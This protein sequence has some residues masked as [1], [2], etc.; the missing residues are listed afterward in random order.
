MRAR[1]THIPKHTFGLYTLPFLPR[2]IIC[3]STCASAGWQEWGNPGLS[4]SICVHVGVKE[5]KL[6]VCVP[7]CQHVG[8]HSCSRA[9][10]NSVCVWYIVERAQ[11]RKC[12]LSSMCDMTHLHVWHGSFMCVAWLIHMCGPTHSHVWHDPF[13]CVA[14]LI[15]MCGMTHEY[16]WYD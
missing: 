3:G 5:E 16:F 10:H 4:S 15:H 11:T 7:A 1:R 13:T 9:I 14:W 2:A 8:T 6:W 12:W